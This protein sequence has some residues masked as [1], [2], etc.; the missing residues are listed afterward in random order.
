ME[1]FSSH[2]ASSNRCIF[3]LLINS[4]KS[5]RLSKDR[6]VSN[7]IESCEKKMNVHQLFGR[8]VISSIYP[9]L[10]ICCCMAAGF[11]LTIIIILTLASFAFTNLSY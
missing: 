11:Q 10:T 5:D 3:Y 7:R 2:I 8:L 4:V 6:I 1:G 9:Y